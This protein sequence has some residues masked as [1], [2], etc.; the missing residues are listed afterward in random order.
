MYSENPTPESVWDDYTRQ[1]RITMRVR[2]LYETHKARHRM[3][4]SDICVALGCSTSCFYGHINGTMKRNPQRMAL[5]VN[6]LGGDPAT[7]LEDQDA[8]QH[9]ES[10]D[11]D[12]PI[13]ALLRELTDAQIC[14]L[15]ISAAP[16][17]CGDH[18]CA[19]M[20]ECMDVGWTKNARPL[21]VPF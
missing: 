6:F 11:S 15:M 13:D 19:V 17:M 2:K 20:N 16:R 4:V 7:I 10:G 1:N 8:V 5:L 18:L 9:L 3:R 12:N 14:E 21:E